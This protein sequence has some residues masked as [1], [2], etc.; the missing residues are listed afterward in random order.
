MY[1]VGFSALI[2]EDTIWLSNG[3]QVPI[4]DIIIDST[5]GRILRTVAGDDRKKDSTDPY[6]WIAGHTTDITDLLTFDERNALRASAKAYDLGSKA[7]ERGISPV[8]WASLGAVVLLGG[9]WFMTR[10]ASK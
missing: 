5:T 8:I 4:K 9:F 1:S 6:R 2:W 7:P 3:A 10:K